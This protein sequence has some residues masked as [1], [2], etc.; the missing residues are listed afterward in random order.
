MHYKTI[1]AVTDLSANGNEAVQRAAVIAANCGAELHL[2]YAPPA[3]HPAWPYNEAHLRELAR[4]VT[5]TA[6]VSVKVARR[7]GASLGD[8]AAEANC[9]DLLVSA[10]RPEC[11]VGTFFKG[12]WHQRVMR[13]TRCPVLL[14]RSSGRRPYAKIVVAVDFTEA[15]RQ[16]VAYA[17]GVD[18]RAHLE[19]FHAVSR[20][21]EAKLRSADVSWEIVKNFRVHQEAQARKRLHE[22]SQSISTGG[23][24]PTLSIG[25]GEPGRQT[26]LQQQDT[27][28]S[29]IVVGKTRRSAATEFFCGAISSRV[30]AW[31]LSDVLIVPHD[32]QSSSRAAAKQRMAASMGNARSDAKGSRSRQTTTSKSLD[33]F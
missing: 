4:C 21:D 7:C 5:S 17:G 1:L 10:Y 11:L 28:A 24:L 15:A 2:M 13:L 19:L 29:L 9:A 32:R 18:D 23:R 14:T 27:G 26:S 8:V 30:L 22:L 6:K 12:E 33:A 16:L 25:S 31:S 3:D 20:M